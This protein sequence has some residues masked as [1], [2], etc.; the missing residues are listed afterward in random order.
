MDLRQLRYFLAIVDE[1]SFTRA[2]ARLNVAQPALSMHVRNMEEDLGTILLLRRPGGVTPTEAG[3]LLA[4]RARVLVADLDRMREEVR[5]LGREPAGTVR[6]GLPGTMSAILAVPLVARCRTKFPRI[7]LVIA[8]AMSGFVR[9]WLLEGRIELAVVYAAL[10]ETGSRTEP[11][12]EEELVVL[13][14]AGTPPTGTSVP[15]G[16]SAIDVLRSQP[17][18]LP[19]GSH[20][21]RVLLD[22]ELRALDIPVEPAI[23]VDSY[24]NIKRLVEAG[25]GCSVLPLHAVSPEVSVG[26]LQVAPFAEPGLRRG[27]HLAHSTTRPLTRAATAVADLLKDVVADLV[28]EGDWAGARAANASG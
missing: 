9:D 14:P 25:L 3:Q 4:G 22:R 20:G 27:V 11:L 24:S 2:A 7:K 6:L 26:T 23:E 10:T 28:T 19:S 5:S 16:T 15:P 18:I 8:E 17:L 21:L 1:G 13:F 12:L